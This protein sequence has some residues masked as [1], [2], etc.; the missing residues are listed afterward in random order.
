M[1]W[2]A[3]SGPGREPCHPLRHQEQPT[4]TSGCR[5]N[6]SAFD[7]GAQARKG[8]EEARVVE[9]REKA[10]GTPQEI[11]RSDRRKGHKDTPPQGPGPGRSSLWPGLT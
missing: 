9:T 5:A 11:P 2:E 8:L 10:I 7:G 4:S 1:G 6:D 3:R